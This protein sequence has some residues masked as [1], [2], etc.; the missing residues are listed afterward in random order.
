MEHDTDRQVFVPT[1]HH[2]LS[3]GPYGPGGMHA[4]SAASDGE[5]GMLEGFQGNA[6]ELAAEVDDAG[7]PLV[8][9]NVLRSPDVWQ[10]QS[11]DS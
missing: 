2:D 4:P 10:M 5:G 8:E 9:L 7:A 11:I 1:S 3:F 6:I